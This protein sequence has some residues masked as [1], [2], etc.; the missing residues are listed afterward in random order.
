MAHQVKEYSFNGLAGCVTQRRN[1][2]TRTLVGVYHASQA[3]LDND[4][5][6]PWYTVCEVHNRLVGHRSLE[7]ALY[8]AADPRGWCGVCNGHEEADKS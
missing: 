5:T 2:I 3:G 7:L 8:H 6:T 4:P 1:Q